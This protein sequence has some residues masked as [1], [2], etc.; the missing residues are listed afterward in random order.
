MDSS[1][2]E[3]RH[4]SPSGDDDD[5]DDDVEYMS[6]IEVLSSARAQSRMRC[7]KILNRSFA[8][9]GCSRSLTSLYLVVYVCVCVCL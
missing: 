2:S 1:S 6:S 5:D 3:T 8:H 4:S 9:V 7:R